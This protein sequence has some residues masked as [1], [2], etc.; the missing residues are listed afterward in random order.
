LE[1]ADY[2]LTAGLAK[3][4]YAATYNILDKIAVFL[5]WELALPES[6]TDTSFR[7]VWHPDRRS[8]TLRSEIR[9]KDDPNLYAL[10]D[11]ALELGQPAFKYLGDLRRAITHRHLVT[12]DWLRMVGE[13]ST[14]QEHILL[15]DLI[16]S[17]ITMLKFVKA[18]LVYLAAYLSQ[19]HERRMHAAQG[20]V[21]P[22]EFWWQ[23][24]LR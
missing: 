5:K 22:L 23:D 15:D 18:A 7:R 20:L 10:Y 6:E 11:M 14:E 8:K 2:G 4:A 17:G 13:H 12:H 9:E 16:S 24:E 3:A 19:E 1:Y 21:A